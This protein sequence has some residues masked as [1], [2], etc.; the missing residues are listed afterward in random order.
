MKLVSVMAMGDW[1]SYSIV[2]K[3]IARNL[4]EM[5]AEHF[6]VAASCVGHDLA[7]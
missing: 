1:G 7:E 6:N 2:T 3:G 5:E 4:P